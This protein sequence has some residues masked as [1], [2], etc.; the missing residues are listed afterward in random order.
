MQIDRRRFLALSG[1][2]LAT[3]ALAADRADLC[4]RALHGWYRLVL[5]LVRHTATYSPPVAARAFAY[6][7]I[8][9]HESHVG[10]VPGP[11]TLAGQVQ[12]LAPLPAPAPGL[13]PAAVLDAALGR[14]MGDFFGNTGP[15]GQGAMQAMARKLA[16]EIDRDLTP[17][18][19]AAS[20]AHGLAIAQHVWDWSLSDGGA[21]VENLGFPFDYTFGEDPK[22]WVPTS[23]I[24]I[25]Q[26]PLLPN[27]GK[28]RT[29]ALPAPDLCTLPSH[30]EFSTEPGSAFH[31]AAMEVYEVSKA[32]TEEQKTIARFWTD[33]PML[34]PTPPG[35]W[36]SIVLQI[37]ERDRMPAERA[38]AALAVLGVA[39]A[40]GFIGCWAE[41]YRWN[42]V[43]P[44]T[45]IKRYIDPNWETLLIT[46]P[47]P[48]Y[49]SGHSTQSGAAE[50][51]LTA[52]FGDNFA[53]EDATHA[54]DGLAVRRFSSFREAAEE[55]A[56]SRLYGGIHYRFGNEQG[57]VQGRCIGAFAAQL[58]TFA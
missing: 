13:D 39:I 12:G 41:K 54:D 7:G 19:A 27:W 5:E 37:A 20:R 50:V 47:F 33:D 24:R 48:E 3:P 38:A 42:L 29:F 25:Q 28:N 32:L 8:I 56:I 10:L 43:R 22:D 53:F 2:F 36:V 51:A 46:P 40:D 14:A 45:Y 52:F 17:E 49:P 34:S 9:A 4:R 16:A 30:P 6:V 58:K 23:D 21:V 15:S 26:A 18:V 44:V 11:L 57:L 31:A 1:A 55:A 35:H